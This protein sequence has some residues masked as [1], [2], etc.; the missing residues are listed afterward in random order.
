VLHAARCKYRTQKYRH[1]GTIAQL[2]WAVSSQL[3]HV[4][5]IGKKLLNSN[6]SSIC[7]YGERR[8]SNGWDLL[9]SLG[10]PANF[11]GFR[12]LAALLHGT[13]VVGVSHTLRRWKKA[14]PMLVRAAITLGIGPHS[15][16]MLYCCK[17][18]R[19]T[20][21]DWNLI[22]WITT[23]FT[24]FDTVGWV[25]WSVKPVP[26][27]TYYMSRWTLSFCSLAHVT[28]VILHACTKRKNSLEIV[29]GGRRLATCHY[30]AFS[31][32]WIEAWLT[33]GLSGQ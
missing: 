21:W 30:V 27:I 11:N 5:T 9:A 25:I 12:V 26:E 15:S 13:L 16:Y 19:W 17:M 23:T 14:P 28:I 33:D 8:P 6:T 1:F 24:C 3:R 22:L 18:V 29:T 10:H 20:W 4:S 7:S 31:S 2:S 32:G